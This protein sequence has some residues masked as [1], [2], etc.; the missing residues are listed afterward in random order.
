MSIILPEIEYVDRSRQSI[1]YLEHG[2]PTDLC[3]WHSHEEYELHLVL[4]TSG[5]AFIGNYIGDFTPG[6]LFLTGPH[7]PHNWI[8]DK[9]F[10]SDVPVR[11]M[12]VQFSQKSLDQ[13]ALAFPEFKEMAAMFELAKSGLEFIG[14]NPTFAR[15]HLEAIR[16]TTGSERIVSFLRFMLR[17]N[18]HAEKK[19]L[20]F[21]T[22]VRFETNSKHA[23]IANAVDH[24]SKHY[25]DSIS[26]SDA[27][28]MAGMNPPSFSRHF[29]KVTGK[30][31]V[32]FINHIRIA[33]ACSLLYASDEQIS[34]ICFSVGFQNLANFNRHFLNLKGMTPSEYRRTARKELLLKEDI[35]A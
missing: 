12:L 17:I 18:E 29:H 20:S 15:G 9:S 25:A 27:A 14:F 30:R 6:S 2:W 31:F 22:I 21:G 26:L 13:L 4:K 23:R 11:D 28:D 16:D 19:V 34:R 8:T 33:E 3:R 35:P 7:V 32:H 24:I 1:R 10:R 5:R